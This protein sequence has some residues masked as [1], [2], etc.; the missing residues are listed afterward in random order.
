S[1]SSS[2]MAKA[3][4][5]AKARRCAFARKGTASGWTAAPPCSITRMRSPGPG[6]RSPTRTPAMCSSPRP[7][8]TNSPTSAAGTTPA[9]EAAGRR[10][11]A[12][13]SCEAP[14]PVRPRRRASGRSP[15]RPLPASRCQPVSPDDFAAARRRMV[16][17]QL[18]GRDISD[19]R[20]LAAMERVPRQLFGAEGQRR[21]AYD[22][23]ALPI[24][25]GQTISQPYM[26]AR[27]C[28]VLALRGDE[29][30]LD[31]GTGSGYQAAVLAELAREVDTIERVAAL[32]E[33]A[34]GALAAAGY[35]QVHVHV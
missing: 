21:R 3:S 7:R 2:R 25:E 16:E 33:T 23:A 10:A 32:A 20:V 13:R 18:R 28:E 9:G 30:V 8:A 35:E 6:R 5:D 11:P 26:V 1:R 17:E 34:R 12:P 14:R 15:R 24:A 19:E 29:R 22:D 27:I 31:V 4:P